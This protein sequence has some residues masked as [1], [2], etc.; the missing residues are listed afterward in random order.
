M[1]D[2]PP[3]RWLELLHR[4]P[5]SVVF[6]RHQGELAHI[7]AAGSPVQ[8]YRMRLSIPL[9]T[10]MAHAVHLRAGRALAAVSG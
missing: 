1:T 9:Q 4:Q 8:V 3:S 7:E 6:R 10:S 2:G 5:R